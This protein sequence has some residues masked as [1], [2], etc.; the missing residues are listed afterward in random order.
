MNGFTYEASGWANKNGNVSFSVTESR[1]YVAV[2][3]NAMYDGGAGANIYEFNETLISYQTQF[4]M[5]SQNVMQNDN[6]Y[7]YIGVIF[8]VLGVLIL[9]LSRK[10]NF[11]TKKQPFPNPFAGLVAKTESLGAKGG[12]LHQSCSLPEV[13]LFWQ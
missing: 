13:F 11:E 2:I 1:G 5:Q 7:L 8:L 10:H 3:T 9:S 6:L 4:T 12:A